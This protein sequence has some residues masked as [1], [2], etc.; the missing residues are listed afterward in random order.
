LLGCERPASRCRVTPSDDLHAHRR[1]TTTR[2]FMRCTRPTHRRPSLC[3]GE[4]ARVE[5]FQA[6]LLNN[7]TI[8][9]SLGGRSTPLT[10]CDTLLSRRA[11]TASA[12]LSL[13]SGLEVRVDERFTDNRSQAKRAAS[14]MV[15]APSGDAQSIIKNM[16]FECT[17]RESEPKPPWPCRLKATSESRDRGEAGVQMV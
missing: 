15:W 13:R 8:N 9:R 1:P 11:T 16:N 5:H 7:M 3:R 10:V 12:S 6:S 14:G 4:P 2:Q 17:S